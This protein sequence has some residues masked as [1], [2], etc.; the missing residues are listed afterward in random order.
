MEPFQWCL[1]AVQIWCFLLLHDWRYIDFQI[2]RF[3]VAETVEQF[4]VDVYFANFEQIKTD[5]IR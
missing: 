3:A 5:P 1:P 4:K 2:G